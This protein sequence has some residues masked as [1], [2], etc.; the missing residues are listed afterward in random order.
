MQAYRLYVLCL[1]NNPVIGAM[2][3]LREST[4]LSDQARWLLASAYAQIGQT[5]EAEKLIANTSR[6]VNPYDVNYYTYGSSERDMAIILDALCLMNKKTQAFDQLKKVSA[7][8]ASKTWLSTQTT[9]FGLV[10]VSSFIK[11]F[12]GS[13]A[14]QALCTVNGKEIILSG[15]KVLTQIPISFKNNPMADFSIKNNGKGLI[16]VR[17][18][19]KGKPA[20]GEEKEAAENI[21]VNASYQAMNGTAISPEELVQGTDFILSVTIKNLGLKGELKNLALSHHIPSGWEIHNA[22]M[23]DNEAVLKNSVYTYQDI[24]DDKVYTYFDLN[25]GE[26]KTFNLL[27]N[28]SYLGKYY[29]PAINVEAM[30]DHSVYGR[31]KGHWIK[32]VKQLNGSVAVK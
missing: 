10:S 9:A 8:L 28:A 14:M 17:L 15:N 11:K 19:N 20:L 7:F 4:N 3:R 18:V 5:N 24:K 30:Y 1:A 27:L 6:E 16:Y 13:S 21:T 31:T 22:R 26:S 23:D 2:N 29:L 12:G 32:V 25:S